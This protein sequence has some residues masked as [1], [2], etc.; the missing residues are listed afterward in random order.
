M[1]ASGGWGRLEHRL[2]AIARRMRSLEWGDEYRRASFVPYDMEPDQPYV[3]VDGRR[4]LMMSSYS[5]LGLAGDQR[6]IEA[7]TTAVEHYGTGNH[8]V[9]ALAGTIPLHEELEAELAAFVG[10]ESALVFTSGYAVNTGVIASMFGPDDTLLVDKTVHASLI[11]GAKLAGATVIRWRH[12]DPEHLDRKMHEVQSTGL[13]VVVVDSVY[14][15][16]GDIARLP[17][18]REVADRWGALVMADE[19]HALGVIGKTGRGIEEHYGRDDLVDVKVGTLSKGIPSMGGWVAGPERLMLFLKYHARPFLFSAAL[20]PAQAGAALEALRILDQ[21]PERVTHIQRESARLRST[22]VDAGIDVG[23]SETAVIPIIC[24][25]DG[26]AYDYAMAV[27]G[28]GV[29]GLPVLTPAV[30]N[31]L[32]RLRISV[33]ARHSPADVDLA[34]NAFRLA[35][36]QTHLIAA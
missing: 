11:D 17:E 23:Q 26:A 34:A 8:G 33:T 9:R 20:G 22:L 13:R 2:D 7:A 16:D 1:N 27:K 32:A 29:I 15:M 19:A 30:P 28:A 3:T 4:L 14:S 31:N 36:Y 6:V 21:E 10:R 25:S 35:A 5:Y 12:N 18:I 24:G